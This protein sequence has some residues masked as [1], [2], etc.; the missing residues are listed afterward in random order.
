[1]KIMFIS[2]IHG[3]K[4]NLDKIYKRYRELNCSKLVVLGDLYYLY[5][6]ILSNDYDTFYVK[7]FLESFKDEL[8]CIKGNCD[9]DVDCST[10]SFPITLGYTKLSFTNEDIYI[11][12]GDTYNHNSWNKKDSILIYGHFHTPFIRKIDSNLYVNTGS[13]SLPRNNSRPS[14]LI[15]DRSKFILYDINNNIID[16]ISLD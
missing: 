8:I 2:D 16:S 13:I 14:Y 7:D 3:I 5:N 9:S 4:T 11:T 10:S 12:H 15:Y 6:N 1:M